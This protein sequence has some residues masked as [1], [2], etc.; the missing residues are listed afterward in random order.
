MFER[1]ESRDDIRG[2]REETKEEVENG[3][4]TAR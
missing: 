1:E 4:E 3:E 2:W